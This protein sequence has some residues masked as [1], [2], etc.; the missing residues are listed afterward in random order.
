MAGR[1]KGRTGKLLEDTV[2]LVGA[3]NNFKISGFWRGN[4]IKLSME[5]Q[6]ETSGS[7]PCLVYIKGEVAFSIRS[8][9]DNSTC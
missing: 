3:S 6:D 9:H 1:T 7:S 5:L 4:Q 2:R 8:T